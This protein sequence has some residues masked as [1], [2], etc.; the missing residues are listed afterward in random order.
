MSRL[1]GPCLPPN[2]PQTIRINATH[3]QETPHMHNLALAA[4]AASIVV[5]ASGGGGN[6]SL[7]RTGA[8]ASETDPPVAA[9]IRVIDADT[10]ELDGT[11]WRLAGIDAPEARQTC[12][13]WGRTWE[14]GAAA[15]EALMSRASG[16][17][18]SGSGADRYGRVIGVCSAGGE[19]LNAWLVDERWALAYRQYSQDYVDEEE[20]ARARKRGIHRGEFVEPWS[21]RHGDGLVGEDT[22]AA[23]ASGPLDATALADRMLRGD[24]AGLF[25]HWMDDSVSLIVEDSIVVS[26]GASPGTNPAAFR[27]RGVARR[28][29]RRRHPDPGADRRRCS[30]RYRRLRP[31][32]RRHRPHRTDRRRRPQQARCPVGRHSGG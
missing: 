27:R 21:W 6:G 12:R 9:Q 26:F 5:L 14:C 8:P 2:E 17:G 13:A 29:C 31:P 30:H 24:I 7:S 16:M 22:F 19:D 15:S 28:G 23:I 20:Q 10:V 3:G 1:P 11:R 4:T 18:C 25:G 32:G